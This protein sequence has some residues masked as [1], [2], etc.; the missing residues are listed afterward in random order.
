MSIPRTNRTAHGAALYGPVQ[1]PCGGIGDSMASSFGGLWRREGR[2]IWRLGFRLCR[3]LG[4]GLGIDRQGERLDAVG[5]TIVKQ[6]PRHIG[7]GVV[8]SRIGR[9]FGDRNHPK[10]DIRVEQA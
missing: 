1:S 7:P 8:S 10:I 9:C 2:Y 4:F 3:R 6:E 5:G